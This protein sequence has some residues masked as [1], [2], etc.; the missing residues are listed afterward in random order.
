[1]RN[2]N[3]KGGLKLEIVDDQGES[4][5]IQKSLAEIFREKKLASMKMAEERS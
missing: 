2:E 5:Q 1:M 3:H 4:A